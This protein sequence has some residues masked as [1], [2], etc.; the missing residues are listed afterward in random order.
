MMRKLKLNEKQIYA[1]RLHLLENERSSATVEKYISEVRAFCRFAAQSGGVDKTIVMEYRNMLRERNKPQTVNGKLCAVHGFLDFIGRGDCKCKLYKVQRRAFLDE[2]REMSEPEYRR[3]LEA[4]QSG[5][6]ERLYHVMLTLAGT[7]IR[8]SELRF[9]TAEAV[10]KG[11]ADITLKGKSRTVLIQNELKKKLLRYINARGIESG[12]VFRTKSGKPLD[13]SNIW[14]DMKKLCRSA[15]VD[16]SKVFPHS[17]RHLFARHFYAIEKD[18]ARLAD[19]L[20][21][22]S[23]ETTRI[24][25]AVSAR[26]HERTLNMMRLII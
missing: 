25:I 13:R 18:I 20:G 14:S 6:N 26:E 11:R 15:N 9:I 4:A 8:V 7:G 17:F 24:Y 19:I 5:G 23:I 22:S 21:H 2:E 12:Y 16:P 3:L 1:Y 10:R